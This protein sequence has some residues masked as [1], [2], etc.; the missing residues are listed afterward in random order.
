[1]TE[2]EARELVPGD[3]IVLRLGAIVPADCRYSSFS[4]L[5][6]LPLSLSSFL[7]VNHYYYF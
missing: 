7:F 5:S 2:V 6:F 4:L 1:M 3:I